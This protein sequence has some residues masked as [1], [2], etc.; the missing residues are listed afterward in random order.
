MQT[1]HTM[2]ITTNK[3]H[4]FR[5]KIL[6]SHINRFTGQPGQVGT[7]ISGQP[8][9]TPGSGGPRR[10]NANKSGSKDLVGPKSGISIS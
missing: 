10:M 1:N 8:A 6:S 9:G 3:F 2:L 7:P 4:C 5:T